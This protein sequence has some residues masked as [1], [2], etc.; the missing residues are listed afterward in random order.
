MAQGTGGDLDAIGV[1]NLGVARSLRAPGAQRLEILHLETEAAEEELD[2]L[3]QGRVSNGE[4]EAVAPC[5]VN[6]GRIVV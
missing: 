3:R 1:V 4:Y 5:P 6:I 2:V